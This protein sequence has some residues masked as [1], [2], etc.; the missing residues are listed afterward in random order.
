MSR[1]STKSSTG[2]GKQTSS[3]FCN[4]CK[5]AG[6][7]ERDYTS[8]FTKMLVGNVL[9]VVCPT[10]LNNVC[11]YCKSKGHFKAAC[12]ILQEKNAAT[13]SFAVSSAVSSGIGSK[14]TKNSNVSTTTTIH[15]SISKKAAVNVFSAAFEDS[16]DSETEEV[17]KNKEKPKNKRTLSHSWADDAYWSDSEDDM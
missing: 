13:A 12:S 10:I 17:I 1:V 8:H 16:S 15:V 9:T 3:M 11:T 5:N 6:K 7:S 4:V 14:K 2:K